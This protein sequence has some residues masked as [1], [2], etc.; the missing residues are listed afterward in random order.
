MSRRGSPFVLLEGLYIG[1]ATMENSL[2]IPQKIEN[3][4]AFQEFPFWVFTWII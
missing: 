2:E 1:A 4:T 3:R